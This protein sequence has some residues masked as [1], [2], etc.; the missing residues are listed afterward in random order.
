MGFRICSVLLVFFF[1]LGIAT[2]SLL[3]YDTPETPAE[4]GRSLLQTKSNKEEEKRKKEEEEK[5]CAFVN[6]M[7]YTI[8]TSQCTR[9]PLSYPVATCCKSLKRLMCKYR[10]QLNPNPKCAFFMFENLHNKGKYPPTILK[11]LCEQFEGKKKDLDC[12]GY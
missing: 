8:V 3:H 4:K 1:L 2:S 10:D 9:Q 7:N 11:Y 6:N 5:K 12:F